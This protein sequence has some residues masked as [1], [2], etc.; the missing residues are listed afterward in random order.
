MKKSGT[1]FIFE[2][3]RG[4]GLLFC[5]IFTFVG[6]LYIVDQLWIAA[7]ITILVLVA[8]L[9]L[10]AALSHFKT[11]ETTF[12][13]LMPEYLVGG[14]Y[15]LGL[16]LLFPFHFHFIHLEL[17]HKSEIAER[18]INYINEGE[19]ILQVYQD[20]IDNKNFRQIMRINT[21]RD[22]YMSDRSEQ[23]TIQKELLDE[24]G[25]SF[26]D[27]VTPHKDFSDPIEKEKFKF[28]IDQA[29]DDVIQTQS[30][31]YALDQADTSIFKHQC[32]DS[33]AVFENWNF[34]KV[35]PELGRFRL[36]F[37]GFLK[38]VQSKMPDFIYDLKDADDVGLGDIGRSFGN[39]SSLNLLLIGLLTLL[40]HFCVLSPYLFGKRPRVFLEKS[41]IETGAIGIN[42]N[43]IIN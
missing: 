41:K 27:L 35:G 4:I 22:Q 37:E 8:F 31:V 14:G 32:N 24:L 38:Y 40:V 29:R 33:R 6:M 42:P 15:L 26:E 36:E 21:L 10:S 20:S 2:A 23:P 1:A 5:A 12:R 28:S 9:I 11:R 13:N 30:Q 43:D 16:I 39:G 19:G 34:L 18:G 25:S 3:F 17:G 7:F